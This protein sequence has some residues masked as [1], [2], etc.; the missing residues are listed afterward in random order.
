[1]LQVLEL[2]TMGYVCV[3]QLYFWLVVVLGAAWRRRKRA[4][5]AMR[6]E[7]T[8]LTSFNVAKMA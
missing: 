7:R 2:T 4:L 8:P 3:W 1:M 5:F 6:F